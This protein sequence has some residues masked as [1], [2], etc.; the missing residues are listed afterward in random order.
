[1]S[2]SLRSLLPS[3][4]GLMLFVGPASAASSDDLSELASVAVFEACP[5]G[6]PGAPSIE[7]RTHSPGVKLFFSSFVGTP[8]VPYSASL[9]SSRMTFGILKTPTGTAPS[10]GVSLMGPERDAAIKA[11]LQGARAESSGWS[12]PQRA[13]Y[14][15]RSLWVSVNATGTYLLQIPKVGLTDGGPIVISGNDL[16]GANALSTPPDNTDLIVKAALDACAAWS[17]GEVADVRFGGSPWMTVHRGADPVRNCSVKALTKNPPKSAEAL[18]V[19]LRVALPGLIE[20]PPMPELKAMGYAFV[21]GGCHT[22]SKGA[23]SV[24]ITAAPTSNG[25]PFKLLTVSF[26]EASASCQDLA[27]GFGS[28]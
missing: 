23:T 15:G 1:M 16:G 22:G 20:L 8:G 7:T 27:R 5:K 26:I 19:A 11:V 24:M 10:C 14:F 2:F 6:L 9:G 3:I 17:G 18:R 28:P 21:S 13:S 12:T 4:L 25:D